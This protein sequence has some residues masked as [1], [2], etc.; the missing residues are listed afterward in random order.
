VSYPVMGRFAERSSLYGF[1][2]DHQTIP[3][4]R[5]SVVF[6]F[7]PYESFQ[8]PLTRS[9]ITEAAGYVD[10]GLAARLLGA[11]SGVSAFA[12]SPPPGTSSVTLP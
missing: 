8:K 6:V 7:G 10:R 3:V 5:R 2:S 1:Y 11:R 9:G 4:N 12:W